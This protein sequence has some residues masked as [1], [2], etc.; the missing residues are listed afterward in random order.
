[1]IRGKKILFARS[2][3]P[4]IHAPYIYLRNR[5]R[6][7]FR[8]TV[9]IPEGAPFRFENWADFDPGTSGHVLAVV[10]NFPEI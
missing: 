7:P 10:A 6:K 5:D 3:P 8:R 4:K 2:A 1:M 9:L